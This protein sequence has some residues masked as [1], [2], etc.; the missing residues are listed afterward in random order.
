MYEDKFLGM[1][2]TRIPKTV[3]SGTPTSKGT[4]KEAKIK[5][6]L[7]APLGGGPSFV[8]KF[9]VK[10]DTVVPT[11]HFMGEKNELQSP[12]WLAQSH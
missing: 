5:W 2:R 11:P 6:S 12:T 9:T 10:R 7:M 8:K 3:L 1:Y 4:K